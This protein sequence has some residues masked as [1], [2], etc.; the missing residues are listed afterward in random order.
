MRKDIWALSAPGTCRGRLN[1]MGLH[2]WPLYLN[3]KFPKFKL[4]LAILICWP[5]GI[6]KVRINIYK[7]K[8]QFFQIVKVDIDFQKK[9]QVFQVP[10]QTNES[11]LQPQ[12]GKHCVSILV[13]LLLLHG[14]VS[15][16]FVNSQIPDKPIKCEVWWKSKDSSEQSVSEELAVLR[17][18]HKIPVCCSMF[19]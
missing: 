9:F 16:P 14:P 13:P 11:Y 19:L 3:V 7:L 1:S 10:Y 8:E 6:F 4:L 15:T 5:I 17:I 18:F 12:A 2:T